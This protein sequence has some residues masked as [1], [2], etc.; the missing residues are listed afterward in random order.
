MVA[1]IGAIHPE[2]EPLRAPISG[3][4]CLAYEYTLRT[5]GP[6]SPDFKGL[7]LTSAKIETSWEASGC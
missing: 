4:E 6:G 3:Q 5:A 7:A 1:A 2:G